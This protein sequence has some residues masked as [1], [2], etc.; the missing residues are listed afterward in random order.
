M[1]A[2]NSFVIRKV[3]TASIVSDILTKAI[4]RKTLDKDLSTIGFV[5][6]TASKMR[7]QS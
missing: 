2:S 4:D 5:E 3:Q 7:K 6:V 1:I